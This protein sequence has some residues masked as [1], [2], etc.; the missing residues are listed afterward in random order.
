[1]KMSNST[2]TLKR[3]LDIL[4][5]LAEAGT[6]LSVSEIAEKVNIPESTAYR[7]LQTLEKLGVVERREKGR[8]GLGMKILYLANSLAKQID[9]RLNEIAKPIMKKLTEET[10]ETTVLTIR[11]GFEVICIESCSSTRLIRFV[12][13]NGKLLPLHQG[14]SGK[15]ILAFESEQIINEVMKNIEDENHRI[16][17]LEELNKIRMDG[18]CTT[19]SEVDKDIFGVGAPIFD[20]NGKVIASLTVAGPID[21]W[22][23]HSKTG[24]IKAVVDSADEI[25]KLLIDLI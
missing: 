16:T 18:Y 25:T 24:V 11:S 12:V 20:N 10:N 5:V 13:E 8:I 3:G 4:F 17:L 15:A 1:M 22:E 21:R 19:F 14:A 23:E 9:L 6:T 7:L 2:Q